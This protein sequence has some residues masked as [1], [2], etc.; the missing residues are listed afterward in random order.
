MHETDLQR[1]FGD[2]NLGTGYLFIYNSCD[3]TSSSLV[4]SM[5]PEGWTPP[6]SIV[7]PTDFDLHSAPVM[8]SQEMHDDE[9]SLTNDGSSSIEYHDAKR[10]SLP[11]LSLNTGNSVSPSTGPATAGLVDEVKEASSW[12]WFTKKEK[13]AKPAK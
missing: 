12:N 7:P 1:Y 2:A 13:P 11:S 4:K 8:A 10:G 5:M 9:N 3:Y 6:V